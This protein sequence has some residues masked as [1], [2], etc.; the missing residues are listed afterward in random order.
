MQR[1]INLFSAWW[2]VWALG[3]L[4]G[5]LLPIGCATSGSRY[6]HAKSDHKAAIVLVHGF[7]G[8]NLTRVSDRER[9][10]LTTSQAIWKSNSLAR[11][12]PELEIKA[13]AELEEDGIL[14]RVDAVPPFYRIDVYGAALNKFVDTFANQAQ[15]IPFAYDWR[16]SNRDSGRA[17]GRFLEQ[18]RA[19]G[20]E[21]IIV[22][23]HSMGGIALAHYL[24]FGLDEASRPATTWAGLKSVDL[25]IT[26]GSPF[27]GTIFVLKNMTRGLSV[28]L[29]RS[30]L[31]PEAYSTFASAYEMLP[32]TPQLRDGKFALLAE[33]FFDF[34]LWEKRRWGLLNPAG[35]DPI[36]FE[37]RRQFTRGQLQAAET[38]LLNLYAPDSGI[39]A[40]KTATAPS[41][42]GE[43]LLPR[44]ADGARGARRWSG[45]AKAKLSASLP[46]PAKL[47]WLNIVGAGKPTLAGGVYW[48]DG[49]ADPGILLFLEED[50]REHAPGLDQRRLLEDGDTTL[51]ASSMELP[52]PFKE[53]ADLERVAS[54]LS[55]GDLLMAPE[56]IAK[57]QQFLGP[58]SKP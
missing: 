26:A 8:A 19:E 28:G 14:R 15:V 32:R 7:Y 56:I 36:S 54:G 51:L 9:V 16:Q 46:P 37:K 33:S 31:S 41:D 34:A 24:R 23:A 39:S 20:K 4:L 1:P 25:V 55:H 30:L 13:A 44:E 38:F 17:L 27:H 50:F 22:V 29:N 6:Q 12:F 58:A 35:V 10:W 57:I 49:E 47:P 18:L 2:K 5:T 3:A 21:K 48:S 45:A 40:T 11:Y 52:S 53:R 42:K 43:E